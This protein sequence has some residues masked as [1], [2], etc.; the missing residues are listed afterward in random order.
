[1]H[2][3]RP[4]YGI[5][6]GRETRTA[7]LTPVVLNHESDSDLDSVGRVPYR[8]A[9]LADITYFSLKKK[10]MSLR[11]SFSAGR[12]WLGVQFVTVPTKCTPHC[13]QT[14]QSIK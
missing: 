7:V 13:N 5:S 8:R 12:H 11:R 9:F 14:E 6:F 10:S 4:F 1:M 3:S 2:E